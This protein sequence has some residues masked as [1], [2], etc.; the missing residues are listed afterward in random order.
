LTVTSH[1]QV[2]VKGPG[3]T[4]AEHRYFGAAPKYR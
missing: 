1:R 4:Q 2:I 3:P